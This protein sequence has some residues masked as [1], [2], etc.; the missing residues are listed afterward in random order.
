[1]K[2]SKYVKD[3]LDKIHAGGLRPG[4]KKNPKDYL[5]ATGAATSL[6]E[7]KSSPYI[8]NL[9]NTSTSPAANVSI[10]GAY[11]SLQT[12]GLSYFTTIHPL[13]NFLVHGCQTGAPYYE[14]DTSLIVS[15][16][17]AI[18]IIAYT[19]YFPTSAIITPILGK[20][21]PEFGCIA[22]VAGSSFIPASQVLPNNSVEFVALFNSLCSGGSIISNGVMISSGLPN[23]TYQFLLSQ[24]QVNPFNV[25]KTILQGN[26]AQITQPISV[27]TTDAN[28]ES[29]TTPMVPV[30]DP[31]QYQENTL[32]F[33]TKYS[34]DGSTSLVFA[35]VLAG[36]SFNILTYPDGLVNPSNSLAGRVTGQGMSVSPTARKS[37]VIIEN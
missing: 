16:G 20:N 25:G 11:N 17:C 27:V 26:M 5:N 29:V 13:S 24:S 35:Y 2:T 15:N 10:F 23:V 8:I 19:Y 30:I 4:E 7:P 33:D 18:G 32:I 3:F 9:N 31:Y 6:P 37:V 12:S 1:M 14:F 21:D 22:G 28:G 34:I 36:A